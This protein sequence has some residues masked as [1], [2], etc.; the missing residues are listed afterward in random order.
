MGIGRAVC[1]VLAE[2]GAAVIVAARGE[3]AIDE[4]VAALGGDP[5]AGVRLDVSSEEAW[6]RAMDRVDARGP[7]HGLVAAAGTLGPIGP[8]EDIDPAE[9]RATIEVNLLGTML[10]LHHCMPRITASGG[11]AVT[12][13]GGGATGPLARYDAYAASKA[14]VV[15]LTE[16]VAAAAA[17]RG[18][19]VNCIAPGFVATRMHQGTLEAGP[20]RAG[21]G[22]Y[23]RTKSDLDRGGVPPR[24]AAELATFLLHPEAE[25]INGKL[26]SAPWDPWSEEGFRARLRA[27]GDL[28]T[29]RRI[30][31]QFFV[32][33][34]R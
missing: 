25:G 12:F 11:A 30:D 13:S 7:L 31:S 24:K 34:E 16:N 28:G 33:V 6:R 8:I 27:E 3:A 15:R 23:E 5:H 1:E 18:V 4:T 19:R 10:A 22:Y 2:A 26:I 32:R 17:E 9:F 14:A 20:G 21:S 29:L